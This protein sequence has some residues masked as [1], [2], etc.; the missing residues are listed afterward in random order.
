MYQ[1]CPKCGYKR[2]ESDTA[3]E[4][5][6]PQCGIIFSKWLKMQLKPLPPVDSAP[7][8]TA[9]FKI[10]HGGAW[11]W[12]K[13]KLFH[14]EADIDAITVYGRLAVLC[15]AVAWGMKFILADFAALSNGSPESYDMVMSRVNLVFH[16]AGHIIFSPFGEF[17]AV[18]GGSIGQLLIPLI[19]CLAFLLRYN[20]PFGASIGLWW[21]GQSAIDLAP[22]IADARAKQMMLLG[23]IT[24]QDS[25][26]YHD[27]ANILGR[28]GWLRYD[29]QIAAAVDFAGEALMVLSFVWG[30]YLIW[31]QFRRLRG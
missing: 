29:Q 28:Q 10:Q 4:D 12:L 23:G 17:M 15:V 27:W 6:C 26:T 8:N 20:N 7:S 13:S 25:P 11:A 22:Y 9:R 2:K 30:A 21:L 16:E 31:T 5:Q 1:I 3:P 24:G 18:L 14:A 19:V